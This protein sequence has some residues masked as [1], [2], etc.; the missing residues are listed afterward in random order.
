MTNRKKILKLPIRV[1]LAM[2][3]FGML[4]KLLE[5]SYANEIMLVG[6]ITLATLYTLRFTRKKQ[7]DFLSITKLVLVLSW[8][9]N[10]ISQVLD[11][12]LTLFTLTLTAVSFV[13][14][15]VMEGTA[16]FMDD[17]RRSKNTIGQILWNGTLIVGSL[18]VITG[19]ITQILDWDYSIHL[20]SLGI[21]LIG[22]Y[23]LKDVFVPN[24]HQDEQ[25]NNE[26][27]QL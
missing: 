12:P 24:E 26:G 16:Y 6:F 25:Q 23:V 15:F 21:T 2:V 8:S 5:W 20:L 1:S 11:L 22:A 13:I 19:A 27:Y 9:I 4:A 14:W 18:V 3:L 17:D 7:K 10:G